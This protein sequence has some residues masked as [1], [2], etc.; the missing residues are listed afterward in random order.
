MR[1]DTILRI[2]L[3]DPDFIVSLCEYCVKAGRKYKFYIMPPRDIKGD[4]MIFKSRLES[5]KQRLD[6][7][8]LK[9]LYKIAVFRDKLGAELIADITKKLS[10]TWKLRIK[11]LFIGNLVTLIGFLLYYIF[12]S[13]DILPLIMDILITQTF[14]WLSTLLISFWFFIKESVERIERAEHRRGG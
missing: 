1:E 11:Y 2:E 5:L 13:P 6:E 3:A 12:I 8:G 14:M 9:N 4:Q 10:Y 7:R